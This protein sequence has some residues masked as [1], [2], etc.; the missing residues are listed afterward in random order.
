M[1]KCLECK[2]KK[3]KHE[4]SA[5]LKTVKMLENQVHKSILCKVNSLTVIHVSF[6]CST[7]NT[8]LFDVHYSITLLAYHDLVLQTLFS[9]T[10]CILWPLFWVQLRWK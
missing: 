4:I 5:K 2:T 6:T 10:C 8:H 7:T 9:Q 1:E 3:L